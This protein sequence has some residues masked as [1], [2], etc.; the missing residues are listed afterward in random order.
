MKLP[1]VEFNIGHLTW[2]TYMVEDFL[3]TKR[4]EI[5]VLKKHL[6]EEYPRFK[7]TKNRDE[8]R[9][10]LL[11]EYK[12]NF[13][14]IYKK[15]IYIQEKWDKINNK[16]MKAISELIQTKWD[17]EII[18]AYVSVNPICPRN[19]E[20]Y[21]FSIDYKSKDKKFLENCV[22]EL[23]HLLYFKKLREIY[24]KIDTKTFDKGKRWKLSEI[25]TPILMNNPKIVKIIGKSNL[26]SYVCDKKTTQKFWKLY[27]ES[28]KKKESFEKFY[29]KCE[30]II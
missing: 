28:L 25:L 3:K 9:K 13:D 5:K 29:K 26:K 4:K 20:N 19:W 14:K 1:K 22:H 15:I 24:P 11:E 21:T 12:K 8:I 10:I 6:L 30:K 7:K 23:I 2:D 16:I 18:V 17:R 27:Q